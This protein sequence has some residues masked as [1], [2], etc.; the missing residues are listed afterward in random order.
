[1]MALPVIGLFRIGFL[2]LRIWDVLDILIVT[3]LLYQIY[4]LLRGNIAFNIFL[5]LLV[6]YIIWGVVSQLQMDLLSAVLG[7]FVSVGVII[8]IIIFQQEIRRFLFYVGN[9]TMMGRFAFIARLLERQPMASAG[10][11]RYLRALKSGLLRMGQ[12]RMGAL[13]VLTK[14]IVLEEILASGVEMDAVTTE[15]LLLSVFSKNSPLHD[16]AVLIRRGRLLAAAC[17][18]PVSDN[19]ALP[20]SLGLRHRAAVGVSERY[21]VGAFVVSEETGRISFAYGGKLF[22]NL[23][24]EE[25]EAR[26]REHLM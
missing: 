9:S 12:V 22:H 18:L 14:D 20:R 4:R 26:L 15:Q 24:D 25:V 21:G 19:L 17:I 7:Q 16:G 1:M 8:V 5:G 3:Y 11:E 13:V 6:I 2:P 23:E 10:R